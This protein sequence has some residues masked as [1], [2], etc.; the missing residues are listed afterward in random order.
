MTQFVIRRVLF[1]LP[2]MLVVALLV[3]GLLHFSSGD[4]A[5][6]IAGDQA[7]PAELERVRIS[8]G[9]D[10]PLF[11]QL[12]DWLWRI[13][14]GDLGRSVYTNTPVRDLIAQRLE[15]T[16]SLMVVASVISLSIGMPL[17]VAAAANAGS[18]IDRS[19]MALAVA[20][21]SIPVFVL[22]YL[23]SYTLGLR[24][25]WLPVQGY[26]PL[27][28]GA[29]AWIESLLLPS[30]SI[31]GVYIAILARTTRAAMLDV[32][33]QSYIRAA[34]ARGVSQFGILYFHALKNAAGPIITVIGIGTAILA[35]GAVVTESVFAIPGIGRLIADAV[36][37]R[38][39]P[40]IQ[41]VVLFFAGLYVLIN[42]IVDVCYGIV[43]PRIK[44]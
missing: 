11:V 24:L 34:R 37:R 43:D 40:V 5:A 10:R 19:A 3:F 16:L 36:L 28:Q 27:R 4:P 18:W 7:G 32:L 29:G 9:L 33:H 23:L 31:S 35:S 26:V 25:G 13:L 1:G 38:D 12:V 21:F 14:H 44:Y 2:V 17:G 39:Y 22:G 8:L 20:G 15:P 41:G 6:L 30:L 42:I